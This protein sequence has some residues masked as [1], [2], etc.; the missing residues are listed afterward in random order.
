MLVPPH[1]PAGDEP[2]ALEHPE[3]LHHAEAR[4]LQ[5]ALELGERAAVTL[6]EAV[7]EEPPR[8]IG[9]GA[10]HE[11]VI[12]RHLRTIRDRKVTCQAVGC[13]ACAEAPSH[14]TR[15]DGVESRW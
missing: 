3:V 7:E 6:E 10:E 1:L 15:R 14:P 12:V 9:E 8:G 2:R 4:H 11:V 5:L 13:P